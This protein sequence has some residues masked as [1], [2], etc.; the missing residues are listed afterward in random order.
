VNPKNLKSIALGFALGTLGFALALTIPNSFTSGSPISSSAMNANFTAVKTAVDALEAAITGKQARV[1]GTCTVGSS[2]A[3]INADGTVTCQQ[4]PT[5]Y[6]QI[7]EDASIRNGS[8]NIASVTKVSTGEF[9]IV[10]TPAISQQRIESAVVSMAGDK[11][12]GIYYPRNPNGQGGFACTGLGVQITN[13]SG[14]LVDGR[15]SFIVP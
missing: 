11:S 5:A 10:F 8:P 6:G 3:S 12:N 15:F 14:T 4:N 7:R 2:I 13:V 9:C 1:T